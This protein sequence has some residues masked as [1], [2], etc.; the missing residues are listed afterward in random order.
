MRVV[1]KKS[2]DKFQSTRLR[3]ARL[4]EAVKNYLHIR[5]QSTRLREAR[6]AQP[7]YV[8]HLTTVSIHA[9]T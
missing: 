1:N 6:Q 2:L 8:V 9:P 5:F 4:N 7:I 3:E